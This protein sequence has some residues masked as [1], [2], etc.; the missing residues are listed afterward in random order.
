MSSTV[1]IIAIITP[2]PGKADRVQELLAE[3]AEWVKA[4]EPGTL[5]YHLQREA[6]GDN[7]T[8]V[9]LET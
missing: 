4:N 1:D 9:M 3:T 7:P 5:K 2:A 6:S 8:F